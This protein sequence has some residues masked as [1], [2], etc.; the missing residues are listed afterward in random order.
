MDLGKMNQQSVLDANNIR[1]DAF[2]AQDDRSRPR[3]QLRMTIPLDTAA[4]EMNPYIIENP[5]DGVVVE[6]ATDNDTSVRL[7]I[8]SPEAQN[9][10]NYTT[11][12]KNW[13]LDSD[14]PFRRALL[15]WDAQSGKT[16]TLVFYL[17]VRVRPGSLI[18]ELTGGVT[19]LDGDSLATSVVTLAAATATQI[20]GSSSSRGVVT[21]QNNTAASVWLGPSTVSNTGANLGIEV[22][23]G[24]LVKWRNPSALY[25]YSVAGGDLAV[26]TE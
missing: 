9:I 7:S 8:T 10:K 21:I 26:M 22:A 16:I 24:A 13:S 25:G 2:I 6:D 1:R 17:G 19:V 14:K 5:F 4:G 12:K 18:S 15:T 11:I 3:Y 23:A 20:V